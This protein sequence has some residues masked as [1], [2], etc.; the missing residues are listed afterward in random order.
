M[1]VIATTSQ[2]VLLVDCMTGQASVLHRGAGLYYGIARIGSTL[3]VAARRRLVSS[4]IPRI[5]ER[6]CILLLDAELRV[7]D[8]VEAPF[9]L[10]DIHEIAWFAERLWLT[11]SFDDMVAIYDGSG[12]Q[13]WTPEVPPRG[14]GAPVGDVANDQHHFNSF[15]F[16]GDEIALLAH[17]HGRSEV[18]FFERRSGSFRRTLNLGSQAHNLWRDGDAFYTCSSIEGKLVSSAGWQLLTGEFPRGVCFSPTHRAVGLSALIE[19]GQ[20]DFAS[21]AIVVHDASW[22]RLHY[23]HLTREGMILDLAP[24]SDADVAQARRGGIERCRFPLLSQLTHADLAADQD[25]SGDV[26]R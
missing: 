21:A 13:R 5:D 11:C 15:L 8:V 3:A 9:A 16:L 14:R 7:R 18:H 4:P 1:N 24:A 6:G 22:V 10:R 17:N 25:S 20:R 12:W 19:R 23:V 2:S 26:S